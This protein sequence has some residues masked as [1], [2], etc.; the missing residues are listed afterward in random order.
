MSE[1]KAAAM[2]PAVGRV[3]AATAGEP[4]YGDQSMEAAPAADP[5]PVE[6][7]APPGEQEVEPA[8][9]PRVGDPTGPPLVPSSR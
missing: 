9:A 7:P 6:G 5:G 4:A 1:A 2:R 8:P 3:A